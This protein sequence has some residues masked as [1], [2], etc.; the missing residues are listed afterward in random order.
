M[1]YVSQGNVNGVVTS[2]MVVASAAEPNKP[3]Y[4]FAVPF[5]AQQPRFTPGNKGVAYT[6]TRQG[7]TNIWVKPLSGGESY[8]L[9]KFTSGDMFSFAFSG[10]GQQ[11]A[12]S[13]GRGKT[14]VVMISN[15]R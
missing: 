15:F 5:G 9:T 10:D 13:R 6:A 3:L 12:M 2:S 11:L 1:L 7:A 8:P 4:T 14:D